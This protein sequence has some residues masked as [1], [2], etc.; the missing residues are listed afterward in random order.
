MFS[1]KLRLDPKIDRPFT[2]STAVMAITT[3]GQPRI[4]PMAAQTA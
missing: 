1:V 2:S 3:D 4:G